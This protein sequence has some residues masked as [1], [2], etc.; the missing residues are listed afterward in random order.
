MEDQMRKEKEEREKISKE[1]NESRNGSLDMDLAGMD[2]GSR[3]KIK[4]AWETIHSKA[5]DAFS[6]RQWEEAGMGPAV[7]TIQGVIDK[8]MEKSTTKP[9]NGCLQED[10]SGDESD[11][12]S[13]GSPSLGD[14]N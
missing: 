12:F 10:T 8:L 4:A 14:R 13:F 6:F 9:P 5:Q 11:D 2:D 7:N 3:A 1:R